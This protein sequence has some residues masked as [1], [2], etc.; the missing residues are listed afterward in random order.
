MSMGCTLA[1]TRDFVALAID[2]SGELLNMR[3]RHTACD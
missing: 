1:I 2:L 3:T